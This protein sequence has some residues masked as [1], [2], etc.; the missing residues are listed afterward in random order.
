MTRKQLHRIHRE[1]QAQRA[2]DHRRGEY[3]HSTL[4]CPTCEGEA[5]RAEEGKVF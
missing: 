3:Q 4:T 2:R 5:E 1:E